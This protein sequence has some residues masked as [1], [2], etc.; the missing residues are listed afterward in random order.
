[1]GALFETDTGHR[2][3]GV[4]VE[5]P[6]W[7]RIL[8]AER[9]ALGTVQSYALGAVVRG[10]LSCVDDPGGT[11][12]GACRQWLA[13]LAPASNLWMDRHDAPPARTSVSDLLPGS[14]RGRTLLDS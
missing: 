9:N 1:V 12:C 4:N 11:P 10:F 2:V 13:E 5:H 8:C 6:D 7:A 3:P 14:F